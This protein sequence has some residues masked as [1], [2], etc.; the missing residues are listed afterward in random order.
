MLR[1]AYSTFALAALLSTTAACERGPIF[2]VSAVVPIASTQPSFAL[3]W[4]SSELRHPRVDLF[5][6]DGARFTR[7][8]GMS[9]SFVHPST[10][11][12]ATESPSPVLVHA[13]GSALFATGPDGYVLAPTFANRT[14]SSLTNRFVAIEIDPSTQQPSWVGIDDR[15]RT[16]W[17]RPI[18]PQTPLCQTL[19]L[20]TPDRRRAVELRSAGCIDRSTLVAIDAEGSA[21]DPIEHDALTTPPGASSLGTP[22]AAV[23]DDLSVAIVTQ[24]LNGSM[25]P[26]GAVHLLDPATS[27]TRRF[28]FENFVPLGVAPV[29]TSRWLVLG[30]RS[31]YTEHGQR[32]MYTLRDEHF[33]SFVIDDEGRTSNVERHG[34]AYIGI[35]YPSLRSA[36]IATPRGTALIVGTEDRSAPRAIV[37]APD[38]R[39]LMDQR[40]DL[41]AVARE[42]EPPQSAP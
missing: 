6:F 3:Q 10:V 7:S 41:D 5:S 30:A 17:R 15:G 25:R 16:S 40:L 32:Y 22:V 23:R 28:D 2:T 39:T 13:A 37:Y 19:S 8:T 1:S 20:T 42:V 21:S 35:S 31:V 27:A 29:G 11:V 26:V 9:L 18:D 36:L 12:A 24:S 38:G 14:L 4:D 33:E 34:A